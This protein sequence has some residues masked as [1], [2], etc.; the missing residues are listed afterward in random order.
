MYTTAYVAMYLGIVCCS[1][2]HMVSWYSVLFHAAHGILVVCCSM[3]HMAVHYQMSVL[4]S[5]RYTCLHQ[6]FL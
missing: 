6:K 3:Q 1:M 4:I 5:C 2:Q